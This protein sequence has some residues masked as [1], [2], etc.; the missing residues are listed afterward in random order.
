MASISR[1][2][3][4]MWGALYCCIFL[5]QINTSDGFTSPF[6]TSS[7]TSV[8]KHSNQIKIGLT[9]DSGT[10]KPRKSALY[11]SQDTNGPSFDINTLCAERRW[12]K[13]REELASPSTLDPSGTKLNEALMRGDFL[14][15]TALH[16]ACKNNAPDDIVYS[17]IELGGK[18]IVMQKNNGGVTALNIKCVHGTSYN[19]FKKLVD[20]G[21]KELILA[22]DD[23]DWTVLHDLANNIEKHE[24]AAEKIQLLL[25]AAGDD[26]KYLL[27]SKCDF[28]GMQRSALEIATDKEASEDVLKILCGETLG[29]EIEAETE[30]E[31]SDDVADE[32]LTEGVV[33]ENEEESIVSDEPSEIPEEEA[34][35][36][37]DEAPTTSE[38]EAVEEESDS[39]EEEKEI[40]K[41]VENVDMEDESEEEQMSKPPPIIRPAPVSPDDDVIG[42]T[43]ATK[44]EDEITEDDEED[45]EDDEEEDSSFGPIL[46]MDGGV[47]TPKELELEDTVEKLQKEIRALKDGAHKK[48][49]ELNYKI[50][51]LGAEREKAAR[52][53]VKQAEQEF[54]KREEEL[55]DQIKKLEAGDDSPNESISENEQSSEE[56]ELLSKIQTLE[57]ER[58]A[59][60]ETVDSVRAESEDKVAELNVLVEQMKEELEEAISSEVKAK[61]A[62]EYN[63]EE[64]RKKIKDLQEQL[65]KAKKS[66]NNDEDWSDVDFKKL[67]TE[68]NGALEMMGMVKQASLEKE[69]ELKYT[70]NLLEVEH[71]RAMKVVAEVMESMEE[72]EVLKQT[73]LEREAA[74]QQRIK[75]LE[76]QQDSEIE[77]S[78]K[79]MHLKNEIRKLKEE[80]GDLLGEME[81]QKRAAAKREQELQSKIEALVAK[82]DTIREE[83]KLA[84]QK[85]ETETKAAMKAL[86]EELN[87]ALTVKETSIV[88]FEKSR[89]AIEE[90][91]SREHIL[92]A[93]LDEILEEFEDE[94]LNHLRTL[95]QLRDT[96]RQLWDYQGNTGDIDEDELEE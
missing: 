57:K 33:S 24:D 53:A 67:E 45:N 46:N 6:Q 90:V 83:G 21:G 36:E 55:K 13:V 5:T 44:I 88:K 96:K 87:D 20:V 40:E 52:E 4:A 78:P 23:D 49:M 35:E 93:E 34:T 71:G 65:K 66:S 31:M 79:A 89:K 39:K 17:M 54:A 14:G 42:P 3:H 38:V 29:S 74:L 62:A 95:K 2:T 58:N 10:K 11:I 63:E 59:A 75:L 73:S 18:D 51:K 91:Y 70:I 12:T 60:L 15:W 32:V 8:S 86:E 27:E 68:R 22:K 80:K 85:K 77:D 69:K 50:K 7:S 28:E 48:E 56:S 25:S 43:L 1:N 41:S 9:H 64:L 82:Q 37:V 16:F 26:A 81:S 19:V 92:M 61:R 76:A 94:K 84:V 30:K 72:V 47:S